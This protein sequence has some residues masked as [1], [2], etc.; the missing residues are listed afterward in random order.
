MMKDRAVPVILL[1]LALPLTVRAGERRPFAPLLRMDTPAVF[2]RIRVEGGMNEYRD[3]EDWGRQRTLGLQVEFTFTSNFSIDASAGRGFFEREDSR[4]VW[5]DLRPSL[6][7][8]FAF[9]GS[10]FQMECA[11]GAGVRLFGRRRAKAN[12]EGQ[13][14][15]LYLIRPHLQFGVRRGILEGLV[16]LRLESETNHRFKEDQ[17]QEFRRHVQLGLALVVQRSDRFSLI[18]ETAVREPYHR[19]VD[20]DI[21]FWNLH[22]GLQFRP[23]EQTVLCLSLQFPLRAEQ[24]GERGWLAY[25][26]YFL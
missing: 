4:A 13:E 10:C 21:G 2:S 11:F 17:D 15:R 6:G 3:G 16:E 12:R 9:A 19:E 25:F 23:G 22:P 14:N 20:G 24:H 18:L 7:G 8:N 1:F 5:E 26:T